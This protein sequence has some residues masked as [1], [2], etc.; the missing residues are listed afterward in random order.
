MTG[1]LQAGS[2][3][4]RAVG[5][6]RREAE[7]A[8]AAAAADLAAT[9]RGGVVRGCRRLQSAH[10][11]MQSAMRGALGSSAAGWMRSRPTPPHGGT[12]AQDTR[13]MRL[14]G[15][16]SGCREHQNREKHTEAAHSVQ[17]RR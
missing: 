7:A 10:Y 5:S 13:T 17:S 15:L 2:A 3:G 4:R 9:P 6:G 16:R 8:A 14:L 12:P 11:G 1:P